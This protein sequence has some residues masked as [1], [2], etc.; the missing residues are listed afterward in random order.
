MNGTMNILGKNATWVQIHMAFEIV[1]TGL[2][3]SLVILVIFTFPFLLMS[4]RSFMES[5]PVG[6]AL[7]LCGVVNVIAAFILLFAVA[8]DAMI[9]PIIF[10][11]IATLMFLPSSIKYFRAERQYKK[12]HQAPG[13]KKVKTASPRQKPTLVTC[14]HCKNEYQLDGGT[15]ICPRCGFVHEFKEE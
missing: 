12:E 14:P 8:P 13:S 4:R 10:G 3:V 5:K 2:Y 1:L 11:A 15:G 6:M 9:F 7:G